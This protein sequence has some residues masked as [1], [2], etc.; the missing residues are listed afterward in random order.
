MFG[1]KKRVAPAEAP[2]IRDTLFG[3]APLSQWPP[4][5]AATADVEPWDSFV[6]AREALDRNDITGAIAH[7]RR[8]LAQ[9]NLEAR[10]VLQAWHFLRER[11]EFPAEDAG[12]V[13]GVVVEVGMP[14]GLDLLAAYVD[15]S[16]RYFNFSG[17]AVVWECPDASLDDDI[18]ALLQCGQ[19][20][21][22]NIGPWEEARPAPPPAGQARLNMLT[23]GGLRFGQAP[24]DVLADDAMAAP[25]F[26]AAAA[27]MQKLIGKAEAVK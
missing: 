15:G 22:D 10:H 20:V 21:A 2:S 18:A 5:T 16:A 8:V 17:A 6:Q 4:P 1:W 19:R 9:P 23:P 26:C 11:G 13:L 12:R 14:R 3:D 25:L 7:W 24:Q 27:L